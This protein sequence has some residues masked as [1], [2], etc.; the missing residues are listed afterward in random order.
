MASLP[1]AP[2]AGVLPVI[3]GSHDFT[4]I[5]SRW[6]ALVLCE[7]FSKLQNCASS[8]PTQKADGFHL[9]PIA[10]NLQSTNPDIEKLPGYKVGIIGSGAAGMFTAMI[11]DYLNDK[12]E[13]LN[14]EYEI[15]EA[16]DKVGGRLFT[17]K[18]P[19]KDPEYPIGPHDYYDVGAMR[20]PNSKVMAR[21]FELFKVLEMDFVPEPESEEE[22]KNYDPKP[23]NLIQYYM[24]GINQPV[25]FNGVQVVQKEALKDIFEP[26]MSADTF[27]IPHIPADVRNKGA[28]DLSGDPIKKVLDVY[29]KE[30]AQA[31]WDELRDKVDPYSARQ[32]L[33]K[34]ASYDYNTIEMIETLDFGNRWYDQAASEMVLESLDFDA[35]QGWWCVEGGASQIALRM[36]KMVKAQTAF[37]LGKAVTAISY[38]D[39]TDR[40]KLEVTVEGE[41]TIRT[42]DAVFNSATLAAQQHMQLEGLKLNWGTKCAIRN[43]GYG[44]SCKV[45]VRFKTLW[46]KQNGLN[47]T[48]GGVGK[49]DLPIHFC[50]YP[51]YNVHDSADKPGVLLV[52]YTWSQEAS[53]IGALISNNSPSDEKKLRAVITH[54]LARLHAKTDD[55]D[56]ADYKRLYKIIDDQWL[57]HYAYNWYE[58]PR[59]AGAFAYF[60]PQQFS[61]LYN[62]VTASDGKYM[63]IGEATSAHHAWVVGALESAVRGVY[64][65]LCTATESAPPEA[66]VWKAY[67]AYNNREIPGPFGPIPEEWNRPKDVRLPRDYSK[68]DRKKIGENIVPVGELL[69]MGILME[70]IRLRQGVDVIIPDQISENDV[71]AILGEIPEGVQPSVPVSVAA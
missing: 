4:S 16:D 46:W 21:T 31:F 1:A 69:R 55:K 41:S 10:Q 45:G 35:G 49:T 47:I 17:Y 29:T 8:V 14:V 33:A 43:L 50:V 30:G 70:Q 15:L 62:D 38:K 23:G 3:P 68:D 54:D 53:R 28:G 52:S 61:N 42:Y 65:F 9:L 63:I 39:P 34:E 59:M 18:F 40:K 66:A 7:D 48:K 19:E 57:D 13:G 58:N 56:E 25:L 12:F 27:G 60:G 67:N 32:Y 71:T 11:F 20:F 24:R 2:S 5:V 64:Q 44:A 37:E 36:K 6:A 22:V 51:S 26:P